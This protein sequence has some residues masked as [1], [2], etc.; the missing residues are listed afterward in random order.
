M[1][2][3]L[4]VR[5][6]TSMSS[7]NSASARLARWAR[8]LRRVV[9]FNRD[10]RGTDEMLAQRFRDFLTDGGRIRTP[11]PERLRSPE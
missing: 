4:M 8:A 7:T 1:R 11:M 9:F 2:L 3:G 10:R 5:A 6:I